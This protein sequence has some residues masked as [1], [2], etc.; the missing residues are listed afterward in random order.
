MVQELTLGFHE[1]A[2]HDLSYELLENSL[3]GKSI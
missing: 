1:L 2:N 3:T